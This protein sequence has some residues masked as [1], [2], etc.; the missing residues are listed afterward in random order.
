[1]EEFQ[2]ILVIINRKCIHPASKTS[3]CTARLGSCSFTA[4][5]KFL[6]CQVLKHVVLKADE[7]RTGPLQVLSGFQLHERTSGEISDTTRLEL[8]T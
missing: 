6:V 4:Y 7:K 1:M 3:L 2:F 5:R 8:L